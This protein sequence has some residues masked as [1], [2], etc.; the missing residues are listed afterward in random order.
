MDEERM[1]D[2]GEEGGEEEEEEEGGGGSQHT[3]T[4]AL[5]G[6]GSV[7]LSDGSSSSEHLSVVADGTT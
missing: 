4:S 3:A 2:D 6:S 7:K 1:D 5:K